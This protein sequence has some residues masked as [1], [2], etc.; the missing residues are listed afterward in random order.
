MESVVALKIAGLNEAKS[1]K[2]RRLKRSKE[3]F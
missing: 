3:L 1:P 2:S